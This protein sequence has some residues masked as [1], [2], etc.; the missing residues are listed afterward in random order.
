MVP[1]LAEFYGA[2]ITSK[3]HAAVTHVIVDVDDITRF[4]LIEKKL[5]KLGTISRTSIVTKQWLFDC[6]EQHED[7]EEADYYP[8]SFN[9]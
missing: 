4:S 9:Q 2:E 8:P 6:I 3:I 1:L 5:I 7:L